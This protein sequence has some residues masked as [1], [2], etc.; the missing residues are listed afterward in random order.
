M[1]MR[2]VFQSGRWVMKVCHVK[3]QEASVFS[4]FV[5]TAHQAAWLL[6]EQYLF[7]GIIHDHHV[8]LTTRL[9]SRPKTVLTRSGPANP[10]LRGTCPAVPQEN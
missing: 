9:H 7:T 8:H 6:V 10:R 3:V 1:R 4:Y 2:E 5:R